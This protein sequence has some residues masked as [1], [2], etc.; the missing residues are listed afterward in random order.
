VWLSNPNGGADQQPSNDTLRTTV[1]VG[2]STLQRKVVQED[3]TSSTC[4]PCRAGN[5]NTRNVNTQAANKGKYVEIKY[6]QNFPAPGNDPYYTVESGARFNYYGLSAIP[7]MMLDGGWNGNSQ[8]YTSAVLNQFY[9][10]PGLARVMG[11][12]TLTR[13]NTVTVNA[14]VRPLMSV[15]AGR[16]VAHMVITER[17][18]RLN[19]RTN[20]ETRFYDVMKKM[21]PNQDGTPL[22]ALASGQNFSL[23]QTFNASSLPASQAVEHFDSLRVVVFVQDVVTKEIYNGEYM[24]LRNA[25]ASRSAQSGP[26]FSLA[27][28]PASGRTSLFVNLDRAQSVRVEVLDALG[29]RVL[30]RPAQQLAAG[31]LEVPLAL[32]HQ[33]P[34]LY[35][36]RLTTEQGVRT[37]KLTIE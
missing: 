24:T 4:G 7:Y 27:P 33:A 31:E 11:E 22:P 36:V 16:L 23:R 21:L 25:L 1:V 14:T 17:E 30:D 9:A 12:Y 37:S 3:F 28:N 18:T 35:T 8:I 2:D 10:K 6:Q 26:V 19:A 32:G 20:G 15:P 34:G 29:R 5:I 13:G